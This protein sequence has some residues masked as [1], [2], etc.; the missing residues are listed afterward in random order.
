MKKT[1]FFILAAAAVCVFAFAG[2]TDDMTIESGT[3]ADGREY[4]Q[5]YDIDEYD[6]GSYL[7]PYEIVTDSTMGKLMIQQYCLASVK[8]EKTSDG[9]TLT[10]YST[11]T[12]MMSNGRMVGADGT[13]IVGAS[14]SED[15]YDG[16][17]FDIDRE[18]LDGQID[19]KFYINMMSRD[20]QF[21]IVPD[22]TQA[23]LTR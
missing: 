22:L 18:A 7:V 4:G 14:V 16:F 21:G 23:K 6:E 15:G 8:I 13:D 11:D 20:T 5:I 1:A 2:C 3:A 10:L 9:I 12:T 19:I 17:E